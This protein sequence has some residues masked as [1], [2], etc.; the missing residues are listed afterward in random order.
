MSTSSVKSA[1]GRSRSAFI[2]VG[3][4]S[5]IINVL[6]LT[7]SLYMLQVYD[8]VLPSRS[9]PTLIGI[10]ILLV[11]LY[12]AFGALDFA[13]IRTLSRIGLGIDRQ[14]RARV[15]EAV[16]VVPIRAKQGADALQPV[17]DLDQ[18]RSF[19]SGL[20]PTA[21]FDMPWMPVYIGLIYFLHPVLGM[22]AIGSALLLVT[23]TL[24]TEMK[25]RAPARE[26]TK[27]SSQ[28]HA[29]SEAARRNAEV[30]Q[31]MGLGNRVVA[32]WEKLNERYLGDQLSM[33][34]AASG[35]GTMS[36]VLRLLLQS[37]ILGLGAYLAI[38][39]ELSAGS[40]IA[41]SIIL[42]RALAPIE[43]A[44]ANW[45]G[46][47]GMRQSIQRLDTLLAKLPAQEISM[48]LPRPTRMLAVKD[49]SVAPPGEAMPTISAVS[50]ALEAGDGLGVIGPSA[51]GKSTLIRALVGAWQPLPRGGSVRLDGAT[52]D[53]WTP[54]ALGRDIG[55]LPQD[56]ELFDGTVAENIARL[57]P[58]AP[59]EAIIEAA[60]LAGIH[61]MIVHLPDG[62]QTRIGDGGTKLSA[63]QRQRVGLARALYGNPFLVV[64]DEPNSNLDQQGD[65]ALTTAI[66]SVRDR[67][68]IVVVVAHRPSALAG[69]DKVLAMNRGQV[70]A[71]GPRDEVLKSVLQAVPAPAPA[72]QP[73]APV[74]PS[75]AATL[76]R[77]L[78]PGIKM[79]ADGAVAG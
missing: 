13:R 75:I 26:A 79:V 48:A 41:G 77:A 57:D 30:I 27:S 60:K 21:F 23:L 53:Q 29:F 10:T 65:L 69:L 45:K 59:S 46:F 68:G 36:K 47:V 72:Q 63:G 52:L 37:G 74:G 43:I 78:P 18:I 44:I 8:R 3:V 4:F 25:T 40:L 20:G 49:L 42:S 19:L 67:G 62:Y 58:D 73:S 56:I 1:I 55:Y 28:R 22:F 11:V 16:L 17:R 5:G 71:F 33:S 39:G 14:L 32:R 35:I 15:M 70:Q 2:G 12:A 34:D 7:G 6:V 38:K 9:V 51:A 61:E 64:L 50:F 31:A 24:L 54:E 76:A 66:R